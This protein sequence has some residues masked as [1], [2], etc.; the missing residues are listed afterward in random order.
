MGW[1]LRKYNHDAYAESVR[2]MLKHDAVFDSDNSED[3][4][5]FNYNCL[6]TAELIKR[7]KILMNEL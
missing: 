6:D 7:N 5:E 2:K 4:Q 3:E 1:T